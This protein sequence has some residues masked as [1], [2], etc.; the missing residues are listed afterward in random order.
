MSSAVSHRFSVAS[1]LLTGRGLLPFDFFDGRRGIL[2][3]SVRYREIKTCNENSIESQYY[4][5]DPEWLLVIS[6]E[7]SWLR[8]V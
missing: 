1:D 5:I 3:I 8:L 2:G 7:G 6:A 4:V